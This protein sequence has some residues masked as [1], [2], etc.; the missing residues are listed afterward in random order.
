M[1]S[2]FDVPADH[3]AIAAD[4]AGRPLDWPV[5]PRFNPASRWYHRLAEHADHEVWLLT[6]LPGQG[7]D[8]HDHG[9]SAGA[10]YVV[11]GV[12]TEE[13]PRHPTDGPPTLV[14]RTLTAGTGRRFGTQHIHRVTNHGPTPA[15]SVHVY[16]PALR[17]MTRYRLGPNGLETIAVDRAGAQW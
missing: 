13:T 10:F 17:T 12:L 16:A 2:A 4:Y 3:L 5:A 14:S 8:L 6:W 1:S 11:A 7:T 9:G 15:I